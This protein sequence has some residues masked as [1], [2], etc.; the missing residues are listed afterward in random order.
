MEIRPETLPDRGSRA[1]MRSAWLTADSGSALAEHRLPGP[2]AEREGR[3]GRGG[4]PSAPL[5]SANRLT[6]GITSR[7]SLLHHHRRLSRH[8][9]GGLVVGDQGTLDLSLNFHPAATGAR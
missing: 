4:P 7:T 6:R 1:L 9:L 3:H 8:L 2:V 5:S